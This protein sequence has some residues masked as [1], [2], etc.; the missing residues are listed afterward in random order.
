[1]VDQRLVEVAVDALRV[2]DQRLVDAG[3]RPFD[4]RQM[5]VAQ[6]RDRFIARIAG[7]CRDRLALEDEAELERVADQAEV[8]MRD[9]H[10]AL[11]H[12]D[13]QTFGFE[14]RDQL[15]DRAERLPGERDQLALRNEL[16]GT[17]VAREQAPGKTP[18]GFLPE[19]QCFSRHA[20]SG[21][22]GENLLEFHDQA[23]RIRV[24]ERR[25]RR[26]HHAPLGVVALAA[27]S[28]T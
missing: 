15:A 10:A 4:D 28:A 11:R 18:V 9:L 22:C 16:A 27:R 20:S 6:R 24:G 21:L 1:M 23:L 14:P 19:L 17:D 13:D 8:D 5:R 7:E 3:T 12:R 25:E 2:I 26:R